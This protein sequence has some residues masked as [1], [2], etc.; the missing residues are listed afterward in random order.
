MEQHTVNK[1]KEESTALFGTARV[2]DDGILDP[3]DTRRVLGFVLD[4]CKEEERR[5]LHPNSFGVARL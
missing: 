5:V 3:R 1:I 4:I 2:W